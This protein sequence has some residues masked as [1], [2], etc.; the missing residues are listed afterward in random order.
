MPASFA[1]MADPSLLDLMQAAALKNEWSEKY[2]DAAIDKLEKAGI[3]SFA[4][5]EGAL[6]DNGALLNEQIAALGF[7]KF[8]TRTL[9]YLKN[10]IQEERMRQRHKLQKLQAQEKEK[11]QAQLQEL[12]AKI[13]GK[14]VLDAA[15]GSGVAQH[16]DNTVET[17]TTCSSCR[18]NLEDAVAPL[19]QCDDDSDQ[20]QTAENSSQELGSIASAAEL[21]PQA[22]RLSAPSPTSDAP[23]VCRAQRRLSAPPSALCPVE[24]SVKEMVPLPPVGECWDWPLTRTEKKSRVEMFDRMILVSE[25]RELYEQLNILQVEHLCHTG[26]DVA[27]GDH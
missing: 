19:E 1:P 6:E 24:H 26:S 17:A 14:A 13:D 5:L 8:H 10:Y 23:P 21:L 2:V 25:N 27:E 12:Q 20:C 22:R 16:A 9:V 7:K 18:D 11:L 4:D 15:E 3:T